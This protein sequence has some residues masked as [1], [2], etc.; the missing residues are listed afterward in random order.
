MPEIQRRQRLFHQSQR[1]VTE[2]TVQ[3]LLLEMLA[4]EK[5]RS[6]MRVA[7]RSHAVPDRGTTCYHLMVW[8]SSKIV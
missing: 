5:L 3:S 7:R 2:R 4:S 1:F 8:I 6:R